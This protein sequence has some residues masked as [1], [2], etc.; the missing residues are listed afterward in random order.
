[1][2]VK[3]WSKMQFKPVAKG[4]AQGGWLGE[5]ANTSKSSNGG[6]LEVLD[7]SEAYG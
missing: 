2:G 7:T 6:G 4:P 5:A 3:R 1:M